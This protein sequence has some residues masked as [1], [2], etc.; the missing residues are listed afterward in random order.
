MAQT[1]CRKCSVPL[2]L[3]ENWTDGLARARSYICR[4]CLSAN[5]KAHYAK[6]AERAAELQRQR[7]AVPSNKKAAAA[8]KSAY[9]AAN[10][11]KWAEYRAT[12]CE[13][14]QQDT[15]LRAGKLLTWIRARAAKSG[16]EFDLTREW[17]AERLQAGVCEVTGI[18]MELSKPP[19]SR[20]HPW[21]PS[22]DRVDS[23]LGYTQGNCRVVCWIY[24][25]AKSEWSDEVVV[26]FAKALSAR[27]SLAN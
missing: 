13:R 21:A 27:S 1:S 16:R 4:T 10:K 7:L 3:G 2:V 25:M 5:G 6:H 12:H 19:G 15:F 9:Y 11:E 26:T 24:N 14:L 18:P 20:F 22:V 23:K 8:L 17:I